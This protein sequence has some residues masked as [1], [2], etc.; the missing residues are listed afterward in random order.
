MELLGSLLKLLGHFGSSWAYV[1]SRGH[2]WSSW[3]HC[4]S[5]CGAI[6]AYLGGL[7]R[8]FELILEAMDLIFGSEAE[9]RDFHE[10]VRFPDAFHLFSRSE[11][12]LLRPGRG[13]GHRFRALGGVSEPK[14]PRTEPFSSSG[15][16]E[17]SPKL[18]KWPR[19]L[20]RSSHGVF[21]RVSLS[22]IRS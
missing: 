20:A 19:N 18:H 21:S 4:Q 11:R 3:G 14:W 1:C 5:S 12:S 22:D 8:S 2:F 7:G 9:N 6:W 13:L 16:L 10:N 15:G 17:V